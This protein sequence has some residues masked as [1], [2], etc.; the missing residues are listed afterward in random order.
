MLFKEELQEIIKLTSNTMG[1]FTAALFLVK[2]E[3]LIALAHHSLSPNFI[4]PL[5]IPMENGGI[6]TL[7][8]E[9][10]AFFLD[11]LDQKAYDIPYYRNEEEIKAFM[12][13][14][15]SG[16]KG[17]LMVDSNKS[18]ALTEKH[19]KLLAHFAQLTDMLLERARD[20]RGRLL[21]SSKYLMVEEMLRHLHP[22]TS[23]REKL[24]E[25]FA[26][27]ME[28]MK[29]EE[30]MVVSQEGQ[31]TKVILAYGPLSVPLLDSP[32]TTRG[33]P[34]QKVLEGAPNYGHSDKEP[35]SFIMGRKEARF[36]SMIIVPIKGIH[37]ALGLASS[38]P[39]ALP[40]EVLDLVN[41]L[42]DLLEPS[43]KGEPASSQATLSFTKFWE[44]LEEKTKEGGSR[45]L[46][47]LLL[48]CKVKNIQELDK[49]LGILETEKLLQGV[50]KELKNHLEKVIFFRGESF[51]GYKWNENSRILEASG[52]AL[53]KNVPIAFNDS[54]AKIEVAW[55]V[56]TP[57]GKKS[58]EESLRDL[59][60]KLNSGKKFLRG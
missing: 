7:A 6:L 39:R 38:T 11:G 1:A 57:S 14:R 24:Q 30:A 3:K 12:A 33:T 35:G 8:L 44:E 53:Q 50:E 34:W 18:Y 27:V 51:L 60:K 41:L 31:N 56:L 23:S 54:R 26:S 2:G 15:L 21:Y 5:V 47:L 13:V 22:P 36:P 45:N 46:S 59:T 32:L 58:I 48:M 10:E 17:I 40:M 49:K 43:L 25:G 42:A 4:Y 29:V 16:G 55:E 20:L 37:G 28:T 52:K 9:Q 19:H